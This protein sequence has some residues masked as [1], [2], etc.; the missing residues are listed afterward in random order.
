MT[1]D[2]KSL[3]NF[4]CGGH[5]EYTVTWEYLCPKESWKI[6]GTLLEKC[7]KYDRRSKILNI[8]R[9]R[10]AVQYYTIQLPGKVCAPEE[11]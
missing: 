6:C 11:N 10:R 7:S 2:Q 4:A 9:L 8:F 5:Y 3:K 1:E